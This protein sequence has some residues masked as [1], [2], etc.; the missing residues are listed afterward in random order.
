MYV[1]MKDMLLHAHHNNYAVMAI[2]CV[3]MEQVK[4]VIES[5]E[6]EK[7]AVII[8]ISPRQ[9]KAHGYGYIMAPLIENLAKRAS[10]P[11]AFN[12]DHGANFED[13]TAAMQY[14]FS[15][16]MIDSSS[17]EFE[18]NVRRTQQIASLAHGMGLS[19]EAELGH[20]GQAAQADDSNVDLYTNVKQAKEFVERTNCDCLAVAIGT[21]HGAY[22]KGMIPKLDFE[23]LK[24]L[25]AE[26]DMPLVLH[27]GSGAG[28]E[29][30]R[31]AVACGINKIN[32]CTDLMRHATNASI[33]T[34][35]ENPQIDYMDLSGIYVLNVKNQSGKVVLKKHGDYKQYYTEKGKK[36][37]ADK[38]HEY[39]FKNP[40]DESR[41]FA[42][43][44][45]QR[46]GATKIPV[47]SVIIFPEHAEITWDGTPENEIPVI[48]RKQL[49]QT[50][51]EENEKNER[52][53]SDDQIDELYHLL[54]D[55]SIELEK[56]S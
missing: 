7:S 13:I 31:K 28:E 1:S 27:G 26:L 30:I 2:N 9:M 49:I 56:N 55:E 53:L 20:V 42:K 52:V 5:A 12:L 45:E 37:Q 22:P 21:A 25:K 39:L 47:R 16:V 19:C 14:G 6:E 34:L 38:Q 10:V 23:R 48:H 36:G 33:A 11:V 50:L 51:K 44:I 40:M 41:F 8:N 35:K 18:E 32:V 54:A 46:I 43:R 15:S 3:N 4:A 24:E 17:Y 29:N